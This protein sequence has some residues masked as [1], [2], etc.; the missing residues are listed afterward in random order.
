MSKS[1]DDRLDNVLDLVA[2]R[3]GKGKLNLMAKGFE[4]RPCIGFN[5]PSL[6][7]ALNGGLCRGT[8]NELFGP[9]GGGKTTLALTSLGNSKKNSKI[10]VIIDAEQKLDPLLSSKLGVD[11]TV[12]PLAQTSCA[13]EAFDIMDSALDGL[14][15]DDCILVD[16]IASLVPRSHVEGGIDASFYGGNSVIVSNGVNLIKDKVAK[17]GVIVIF[18][19]QI[20]EKIGVTYGS[21]ETTPGGHARLHAEE[22]RIEV[23]RCG[24]IKDGGT[25]IG[26]EVAVKIVKSTHCSPYTV[27]KLK[28]YFG[29]GFSKESSLIDLALEQGVILQAGAWYNYNDKKYQGE[30]SLIDLI[31]VE[32][33]Y[34]EMLS[35]VKI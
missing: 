1:D 17:K 23:R 16:S 15:E 34:N 8:M 30:K 9:E 3:V 6:D 18:I 29:N 24:F 7:R 12:C 11:L 26:Q 4:R 2:K 32:E 28:L 19:N 21:N 31:S 20:R 27:T 5:L 33:A 22:T 14:G 25:I 35:K 13:E 10:V